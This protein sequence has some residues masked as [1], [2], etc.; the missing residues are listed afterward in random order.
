MKVPFHIDANKH[1]VMIEND[2][3]T[4]SI[5]EDGIGYCI[6]PEGRGNWKAGKFDANVDTLQA[7]QEI[8]EALG[9]GENE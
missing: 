5:D 7:F 6:R 1:T 9:C 2:Y 3:I 4:I 8:C